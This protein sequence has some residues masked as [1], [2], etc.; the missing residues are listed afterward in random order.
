M[1]PTQILMLRAFSPQTLLIT[2][3][4]D[5]LKKTWTQ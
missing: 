4:C 3:K 2:K 5:M 1:Y